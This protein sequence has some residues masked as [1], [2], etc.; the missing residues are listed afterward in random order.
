[1]L[2]ARTNNLGG[3]NVDKLV[4]SREEVRELSGLSLPLI[5]A[6]IRREKHPLPAFK[7]GRRVLIPAEGYRQWL[8][9]ESS[10]RQGEA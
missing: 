5:D 6:M 2:Y 7:C 8:L 1:M 3:A 10:S 4:L 9:E